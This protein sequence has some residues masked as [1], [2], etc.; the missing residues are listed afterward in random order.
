MVFAVRFNQSNVRLDAKL[1]T[2]SKCLNAEFAGFQKV[3]EIKDAEPYTGAYEVTPKV[4]AQTM[5][6][7]QKLMAQDVTIKAIPIYDVTN[8]TGG[9]TVYIA[10]EV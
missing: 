9:S 8:N 10:R 4:E 3:S 6:T 5:H 1:Q 7:A 2:N